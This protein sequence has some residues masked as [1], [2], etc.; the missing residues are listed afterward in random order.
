M[1]NFDRQSQKM[2]ERKPKRATFDLTPGLRQQVMQL[3]ETLR[4]PASQIVSYALMRFLRAYS[5]G[6]IDFSQIKRPSRSP[7]YDWNLDLSLEDANQKN[8]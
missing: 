6:E 2:I 5:Y 3:S 4:I 8:R 7:R 1:S